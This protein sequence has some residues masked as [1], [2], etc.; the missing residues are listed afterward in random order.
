MSAG[1]TVFAQGMRRSGTTV[2]FDL[3]MERGDFT[4]FYE[5]LARGLPAAGG[6]SGLHGDRDLFDSLRRARA[7][8]LA[9]EPAWLE[10]YPDFVDA[11]RFNHGAP[12]DA[13]LEFEVELPDYC[14][15][16]LA[17]LCRAAPC[18]FLKFTRM[19]SK[20]ACLADIAPGAKFIH[21]VRDPRRV[22]VSYLFGKG[23]RYRARFAD[24]E[25]FFTRLSNATAW[26]S[27]EFSERIRAM[28]EYA[29]R[30]DCQ[31]FLR[32]LLIWKYKF[33]RTHRD[34]QAAFGANYLLFRHDD[35]LADPQGTLDRLGAFLGA[36]LPA[37]AVQWTLANLKAPEPVYAGDDPRWGGAFRRLRMERTLSDAGF[38]GLA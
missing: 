10:R 20:S 4:C 25:V 35:L 30:G 24:P 19:H 16:Y 1:I 2:L 8:F 9:A 17:F 29:V 12:R 28:P 33:E 22:A 6:G 32:I 11:N 14:R 26:S 5:P 3:F 34:A 23:G 21:V 7:D 15:A 37:Q 38:S 13:A 27:R 31:D 18:T 36:P